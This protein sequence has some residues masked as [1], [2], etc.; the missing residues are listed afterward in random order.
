MVIRFSVLFL[1]TALSLSGAEN[2]FRNSDFS[3]QAEEWLYG[4]WGV[5]EK[6]K[7]V[8]PLGEQTSRGKLLGQK[9]KLKTDHFYRFRCQLKNSRPGTIRIFFQQTTLPYPSLGFRRDLPLDPGM[10]TIDELFQAE[11]VPP[12]KEAQWLFSFSDLPGRSELSGLKLEEMKTLSYSILAP[13]WTVQKVD[14]APNR[15]DRLPN[16]KRSSWKPGRGELILKPF[17]KERSLALISNRFHSEEEGIL[18]LAFS[19]NWY[20]TVYLNGKEI[21]RSKGKQSEITLL[22]VQKGENFLCILLRAGGNGWGFNVGEALS[23]LRFRAGKEWKAYQKFDHS[24]HSGSALDLSGEIDAPA[25]KFGRL[26]AD[27]NG[28]LVFENAP[29]RP[30]RF[31][32]FNGTDLFD[33]PCTSE[34]FR[35]KAKFF[36]REARRQGYQLFR[37]HGYLDLLCKGSGADKKVNPEMLE[38][39]DILIAELKK[40]GIYLHLVL[41]SFGLY[42]ND[43]K[44]NFLKRDLHRLMIY[45]D[46]EWEYERLRFAAETLFRHINPETG[47]AWKD[48]P[49]IAFVEPYNEQSLGMERASITVKRYPEARATLKRMFAEWQKKK[50]G[51]ILAELPFDRQGPAANAAAEFWM[52]RAQKS[53]ERSRKIVRDAGYSGLMSPYSFSK[54]IGHAA[55]RWST[56]DVVDCHAYF[57]HPTGSR[58]ASNS[59]IEKR[60]NYWKES[61]SVRLMGR[62]MVV[63]EYNHCFWNPYRYEMGAL[64]SGYSA[65]QGFG[66]LMIH[67][68]PILT[69]NKGGIVN[70]F[71]VATSPL[72]RA[73]Q[74]LSFCLF[75]RGDVRPSPHQTALIMPD[76]FL[77][78]KRNSARAVHSAQSDFALITGFG[79]IFPDQPS[80]PKF[81]EMPKPDF[82]IVPDGAAEILSSSWFSSV[83]SDS[84]GRFNADDI[85]KR[86]KR[87]GILRA[88]NRSQ[89]SKGIFQS[90]TEELFLDSGRKLLTISTPRSEA[91]C[92]PNGKKISL[93]VLKNL[94]L[95]VPGGVALCSIDGENALEKS[96]RLVLLFMTEEANSYMVLSGDHEVMRMQGNPPVL[97]RTGTLKAELRLPGKWKLYA[98]AADG[99]RGEK[100]PV[101]QAGNLLRLY[102]DTSTLSGGA[103]VFFELEK[104]EKSISRQ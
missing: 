54:R 16:G 85:V 15:L 93:R 21:R 73:A 60:G 32:G 17:Q 69:E 56:A 46:G 62:P 75:R 29:D 90:D 58:I 36:A 50:Y 95:S 11:E 12:G 61:C 78:E 53:A 63:G 84:S 5:F 103:T 77:T 51:K 34:E 41:L 88:S 2:L 10:H 9:L 89:P 59:S 7:F 25:G 64:F 19:A 100:I 99:T 81:S 26:N 104:E 91:V 14:Q 92:M 28:N 33:T 76:T 4:K 35:K 98:L 30:V 87:S 79:L 27:K 83:K 66:A 55:A 6:G 97:C 22:P 82:A 45:L 96:R 8:A 57:N 52:E 71:T 39:W 31:L 80:N 24:V 101:E 102:L 74:F 40:E 43:P 3:R 72:V 65:F 67:C 37:V 48:E 20:Y 38:K 47:I 94:E 86:M 44:A 13:S 68:N 1:L 18:P 70:T 49:A 23:P 42:S